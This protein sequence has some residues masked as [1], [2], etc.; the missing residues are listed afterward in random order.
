MFVSELYAP[1]AG[2]DST[3]DDPSILE[4]VPGGTIRDAEYLLTKSTFKYSPDELVEMAK[5]ALRKGVGVEDPDI[6]SDDMIFQ[7]PVVGPISKTEYLDALENFDLLTAFPDMDS[8]TYMIQADPFEEG[9]V[10]WFTRTVATY[11]SFFFFFLSLSLFSLAELLRALRFFFFRF[12]A[13]TGPL[14]GKEATGKRLE[15]P[16]QANSFVFN[17]DGKIEVVTVGYVLDRRCGNTGGLGGAFAFFYG[18]GRPLPIPE[19]QPFKPSF[20]FRMLGLV[21]K[22]RKKLSK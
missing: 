9:R 1:T 19:C 16:P 22:L 2:A 10:W 4:R 18:V 20:R 8:R 17:T 15:L 14:L 13:Q 21:G 12:A 3:V 6:L 11:V 7:A 5:N